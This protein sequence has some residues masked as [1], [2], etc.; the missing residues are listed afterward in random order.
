MLQHHEEDNPALSSAVLVSTY[1]STAVLALFF[2][3][4]Q[5]EGLGLMLVCTVSLQGDGVALLRKVHTQNLLT[6][7]PLTRLPRFVS[8]RALAHPRQALQLLLI[9]AR[10]RRVLCFSRLPLS[11]SHQVSA[12]R[13]MSFLV[14]S[15]SCRIGEGDGLVARRLA[16]GGRRVVRIYTCTRVNEISRRDLRSSRL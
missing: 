2:T 3:Q 6:R 7:N 4:L 5:L 12:G 13:C 1:L 16:V 15:A 8:R 9:R 11:W 14:R 10:N